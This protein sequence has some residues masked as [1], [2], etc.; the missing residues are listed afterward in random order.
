M[1]IQRYE[2]LAW[3]LG[4]PR[5]GIVNV[6]NRPKVNEYIPIV[7]QLEDNNMSLGVVLFAV[8]VHSL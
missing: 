8:T 7:C 4:F 2:H 3:S 1:T 6:N 5:T